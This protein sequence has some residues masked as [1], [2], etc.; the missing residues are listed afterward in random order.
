MQLADKGYMREPLT[1]VHPGATNWGF[2][3]LY[4]YLLRIVHFF[5]PINELIIAYTLNIIFFTAGSVILGKYLE[6]RFSRSVSIKTLLFICVSPINIYFSSGYTESLFFLLIASILLFSLQ[7][8]TIQM[9]LVGNLLAVTRN[10][11]LIIG[12]LVTLVTYHSAYPRIKS[13]L[14]VLAI[15]A[16]MSILL[17]AHIISLKQVSGDYFA[18]LNGPK[19]WGIERANPVN[20]VLKTL[21]LESPLQIGI[22]ILLIATILIFLISLKAGRFVESAIILPVILTS[23]IY[24]YFINWRYFAVLYPIY[25]FL[26]ISHEKSSKIVR[27]GAPFGLVICTLF[28]M[29]G[30]VGNSGYMV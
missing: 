16:A 27:L 18:I 29:Y 15:C 2:F 3:P 24:P 1:D 9:I 23:L 14:K 4:P 8:S 26:A 22:L 20:W 5:L 10:T 17:I 19:N 7:Q 11:G 28:G 30:W 12:V 6:Y 21:E 13:T 25:L